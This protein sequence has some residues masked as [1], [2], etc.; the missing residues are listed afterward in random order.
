MILKTKGNQIV[1]YSQLTKPCHGYFCSYLPVRL[2]NKEK[3]KNWH[4]NGLYKTQ[5]PSCLF[6]CLSFSARLCYHLFLACT[7]LL[8][9]SYI[10]SS[11]FFWFNRQKYVNYKMMMVLLWCICLI[12]IVYM[13]NTVMGHWCLVVWP[14][15]MFYF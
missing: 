11:L 3:K 7:H 14:F 13:L 6:G 9:Y 8:I 4:Y 2:P 5:T 1:K 10:V 15:V 12:I